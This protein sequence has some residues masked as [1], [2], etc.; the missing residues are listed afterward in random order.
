MKVAKTPRK[1]YPKIPPKL[2]KFLKF[3]CFP[4]ETFPAKC[5]TKMVAFPD[6]I[7]CS[8]NYLENEKQILNYIRSFLLQLLNTVLQEFFRIFRPFNEKGSFYF[9]RNPIRSEWTTTAVRRVGREWSLGRLFSAQ[10]PY[11]LASILDSESTNHRG[12]GAVVITDRSVVFHRK[13][14]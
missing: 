3:A 14:H 9:A 1:F 4:A 8:R 6:F 11:T 10:R 5:S 2:Y 7:L 12:R 13:R